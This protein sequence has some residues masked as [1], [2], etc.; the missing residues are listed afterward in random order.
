MSEYASRTSVSILTASCL[1][2][3]LGNLQF[4]LHKSLRCC[5]FLSDS[6]IFENSCVSLFQSDFISLGKTE[7]IFGLRH[8]VWFGLKL[9]VYVSHFDEMAC[10][11]VQVLY[12][13]LNLL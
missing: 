13:K 5:L 6:I 10:L 1:I 8:Q 12:L 2:V 11:L 3:S 7:I 9:C 4:S